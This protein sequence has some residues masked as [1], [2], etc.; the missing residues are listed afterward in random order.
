MAE[1][2]FNISDYETPGSSGG[3]DAE[4]RKRIAD[5]AARRAAGGAA[6]AAAPAG[7]AVAAEA[8]KNAAA[9]GFGASAKNFASRAM[10]AG[11]KGLGFLGKVGGVLTLP[12]LAAQ[13]MAASNDA[14]AGSDN[15][16]APRGA[17]FIP[18]NTQTVADRDDQDLGV[19]AG[20]GFNAAPAVTAQADDP[21]AAAKAVI[22]SSNVFNPYNQARYLNLNGGGGFASPPSLNTE[23]GIFSAAA[24]FANE[25]GPYAM[26]TGTRVGNAKRGLNAQKLQQEYDL[27][28]PSALLEAERLQA[29]RDGDYDRAAA[30]SGR[31]P[32]ATKFMGFPTLDNN[33]VNV[34]DTKRGTVRAQTAVTEDDI[35]ATM[36][37][38][39]M[40]RQQVMDR[41]KAEGRI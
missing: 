6:S 14:G 8:S 18:S 40:T 35:A 2:G 4:V 21:L 39:K 22:R 30:T 33:K 25:F 24:D 31:P 28:L 19:P 41:L 1:L 12:V 3:Y 13:L 17:G 7:D 5:N 36:T 11:G 38:N 20:R 9:R 27:K 37:A 15:V 26:R 16:N 32:A 34:L 29:V 23:G 10:S